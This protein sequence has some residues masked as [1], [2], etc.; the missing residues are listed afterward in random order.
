MNSSVLKAQAYTVKRR[1]LIQ[2]LPLPNAYTK[3]ANACIQF[4][5]TCISRFG[6]CI[7]RRNE[8]E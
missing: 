2:V 4:A 5:N 6:I 1:I 8:P 3:S 7:G